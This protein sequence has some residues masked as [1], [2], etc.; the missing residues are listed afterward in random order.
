MLIDDN[1]ATNFHH[2]III[3][4]AD[5]C[6]ELVIFEYADEALE[7]LK[8]NSK[9]PP[10]VIF[11]DINM[12]RMNGWEFLEEYKKLEENRKSQIVIVMLTTS[13]NE[14]DKEK[15]AQ[16]SEVADFKHKPLMEEM[17]EKLLQT[18]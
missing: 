9:T 14:S 15:A 1:E 3:E 18:L 2:Q 8:D 7:Y 16:I 17:L 12:P 10:T 4:D 13:L 5:C 6:N 11:L